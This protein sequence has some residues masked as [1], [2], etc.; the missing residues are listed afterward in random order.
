MDII[1]EP[2][3]CFGVGWCHRH[4]FGGPNLC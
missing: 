1:T 3:C 2:M 4:H